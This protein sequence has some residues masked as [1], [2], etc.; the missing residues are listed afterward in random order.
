MS[1]A[2]FPGPTCS[3]PLSV[4]GSAPPRGSSPVPGVRTGFWPLLCHQPLLD[5]G[6]IAPASGKWE[7]FFPGER[8]MGGSGFRSPEKCI[9]V[10]TPIP[11]AQTHNQ[12]FHQA[13][14]DRLRPASHPVPSP[15]R[16][17]LCLHAPPPHP[18]S[19]LSPSRMPLSPAPFPCR[20]PT[21]GAAP[22]CCRW[23]AWSPRLL[24]SWPQGHNRGPCAKFRSKGWGQ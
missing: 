19:G 16:F 3:S 24:H 22:A 11:R 2:V 21:P 23:S 20:E 13:Q 17:S 4:E 18:A 6:D 8:V 5:L 9:C 7:D 1:I 15:S 12:P 14:N 10:H